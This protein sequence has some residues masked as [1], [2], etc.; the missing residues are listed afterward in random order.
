M[1]TFTSLL[2]DKAHWEFELFVGLIETIVI[3][4]VFGYFVYKKIIKPY[5]RRKMIK[6]EHKR[7]DITINHR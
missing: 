1:E 4:V 6:E 2:F 7:H 3:D 5:M